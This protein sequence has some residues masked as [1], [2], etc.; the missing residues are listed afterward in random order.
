MTQY[1]FQRGATWYVKTQGAKRIEKS[2]HTSD[3]AHALVLAAPFI[4]AHQ[5]EL[6]ARAPRAETVWTPRFAPRLAPYAG[7]NGEQIL[8]GPRELTI[9]D[10]AGTLLRTE[11][12]GGPVVHIVTADNRAIPAAVEFALFDGAASRG[13]VSKSNDDAILDA[14]LEHGAVSGY[15]RE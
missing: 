5:R 3:R 2:L 13:A 15:P 10:A 12:N 11:P 1:L 14:N 6:A 7:T 9:Y 8:A 4:Q